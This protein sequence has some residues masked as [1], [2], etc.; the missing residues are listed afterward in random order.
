VKRLLLLIPVLVGV[1]IVVFMLVRILPGDPAILLVQGSPF[2]TDAGVINELRSQWHLDRPIYEQYFI[3]FQGLLH[4]DLGRS[5]N[6]MRPVTEE[7]IPRFFAT[8]QLSLVAIAIATIIGLTFGVL[9]AVKRG[10]F[11]DVLTGI[12]AVSGVSMPSF[13]FA[14]MLILVFAVR[15][16]WLPV[17]GTGTPLHFVLPAVTLGLSTSMAIITRMTR[18]SMVEVLSQDYIRTAKAKG[19]SNS[20]VYDKHALRNAL[21]PVVTVIGLQFGYLMAG[22]VIT[23]TVFNWPGIGRLIVNSIFFR[24]FPVIQGCVLVLAVTF[25]VINLAVDILYAYLDPRIKFG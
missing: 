12:A 21:I 22:Q 6:T 19:C 11:F 10:S 16:G 5:I 13:W 23:E 15:L 8:V 2:A 14:L 4:G 1:S 3:W 18:S 25:V 17:A 20:S 24:D 7:I 9:A